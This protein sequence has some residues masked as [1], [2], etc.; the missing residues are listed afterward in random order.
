MRRKVKKSSIAKKVNKYFS[1]NEVDMNQI[2]ENFKLLAVGERA[3]MT[4]LI[5]LI[6]IIISTQQ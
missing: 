2:F 4:R 5:Y 3:R 1:K 6:I